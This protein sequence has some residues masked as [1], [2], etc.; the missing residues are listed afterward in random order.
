MLNRELWIVSSLL[1]SRHCRLA[2]AYCRLRTT[3]EGG[4]ME[5]ALRRSGNLG[6]DVMADA[7]KEELGMLNTEGAK[8][9]CY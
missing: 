3:F 7:G 6:Q 2:S 4:G 8:R 1:T 5:K 9:E